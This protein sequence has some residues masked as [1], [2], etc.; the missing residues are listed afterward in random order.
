[1]VEKRKAYRLLAQKLEKEWA[2][3]KRHVDGIVVLKYA[4]KFWA[5]KRWTGF[6]WFSTGFS[7]RLLERNTEIKRPVP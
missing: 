2:R 4:V 6:I 7:G 3:E 1:M 5:V